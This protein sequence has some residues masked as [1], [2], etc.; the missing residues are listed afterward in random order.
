M[1]N[2]RSSDLNALV[3][4]LISDSSGFIA[5]SS[6]EFEAKN[7]VGVEYTNIV[8]GIYVPTENA[9]YFLSRLAEITEKSIQ[10]DLLLNTKKAIIHRELKNNNCYNT[11]NIESC[12]DVLMRYGIS[13]EEIIEEFMKQK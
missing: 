4:K 2:E 11:G 12:I 13:R 6:G 8:D 7:V 3:I 10:T 9:T 1:K 5:M